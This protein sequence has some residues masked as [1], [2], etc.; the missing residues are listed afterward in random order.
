[1]QAID[2]ISCLT[3]VEAYDWFSKETGARPAHFVTVFWNL[4][5]GK[6]SKNLQTLFFLRIT[7]NEKIDLYAGRELRRII[8]CF[9]AYISRNVFE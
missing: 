7:V 5:E 4:A 1:M 3:C 9:A 6:L 8:V 2:N